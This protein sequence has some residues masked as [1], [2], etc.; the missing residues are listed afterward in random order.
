[1]A[2]VKS[3]RVGDNLYA[4]VDEQG[5]AGIAPE[6][7]PSASYECGNV[8]FNPSGYLA[9]CLSPT[10]GEF[11][12]DKWEIFYNIDG[13][14]NAYENT[15]WQLNLKNTKSEFPG[16]TGWYGS[17]ESV[18]RFWEDFTLSSYSYAGE[19][20][21][22]TNPILLN[23]GL[24]FSFSDG[25]YMVTAKFDNGNYLDL[26]L[27]YF[28]YFNA[29]DTGGA[30]NYVQFMF[31]RMDDQSMN[32]SP[33]GGTD[34]EKITAAIQVFGREY[35]TLQNTSDL[36]K[37][38]LNEYTERIEMESE[39]FSDTRA[40]YQI[41]TPTGTISP[42]GTITGNGMLWSRWI[43]ANSGRMLI[44]N[45]GWGKPL[46]FKVGAVYKS[47]LNDYRYYYVNGEG[48]YHDPD[49]VCR[50]FERVTHDRYFHIPQMVTYTAYGGSPESM[51]LVAFQVG[52]TDNLS[53]LVY[54]YDVSVITE[55]VEF[56]YGSDIAVFKKPDV[57]SDES[58]EE[59]IYDAYP[60]AMNSVTSGFTGNNDYP[61]NQEESV[62][63]PPYY[64]AA[65]NWLPVMGGI[66][67]RFKPIDEY[68]IGI[69]S[70]YFHRS[71]I[72][73]FTVLNSSEYSSTLKWLDVKTFYGGPNWVVGNAVRF[74][75]KRVDGEEL[76]FGSYE[77]DDEVKICS[78]LEV[79]MKYNTPDINS[80]LYYRHLCGDYTEKAEMVGEYVF[81]EERASYPWCDV[82]PVPDNNCIWSDWVEV[83]SG[84]LIVC[85]DET[86]ISKN[87]YS[88]M[89]K[90]EGV[91]VDESGYYSYASMITWTNNGTTWYPQGGFD[92][93]IGTYYFE[94]PGAITG[95][96]YG[97]YPYYYKLV[98][99]Q[100]GI[101]LELANT[102]PDIHVYK[103]P[104]QNQ[105]ASKNDPDAVEQFIGV[106]REAMSMYPPT[107]AL[108]FEDCNIDIGCHFQDNVGYGYAIGSSSE[109]IAICMMGDV[110]N[111]GYSPHYPWAEDIYDLLD[112][113]GSAAT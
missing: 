13:L 65:T 77:T 101:P 7:D 11:D 98:A 33:N 41:S 37:V 75:F 71:T 12:G 60:H 69:E 40:Q 63:G 78:A 36:E 95:M 67:L 2:I 18:S 68:V 80:D 1:M 81:H 85:D 96:S 100:I 50:G 57:A 97:G 110:K 104:P 20:W 99:F 72:Q 10:T 22:I 76:S 89:W 105:M 74:W 45:R 44:F 24:A 88:G 5:R 49:A 8:V 92:V 35:S 47:R 3:I 21:A 31:T 70:S 6:Y 90:V 86:G 16:K 4:I 39:V 112:W 102:I 17:D 111:L 103:K 48:T 79:Q 52:Y 73:T 32:I 113:S 53:T 108:G 43:P 84:R 56:A 23:E 27:K 107:G 30:D 51:D 25:D 62:D 38:L 19:T 29:W 9:H 61:G 15:I 106:L 94:V 46:Y 109:L 82:D 26:P 58:S 55:S 64:S 42:G 66:M 83:D 59:W 34:Y 87:S 14:A 93:P 91:Y 28:T 54:P